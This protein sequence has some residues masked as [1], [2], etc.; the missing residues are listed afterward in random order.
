[1]YEEESGPGVLS[2][3]RIQ[4]LQ[5]ATEAVLAHGGQYPEYNHDDP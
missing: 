1:M 5:E 4:I 2:V 3:P